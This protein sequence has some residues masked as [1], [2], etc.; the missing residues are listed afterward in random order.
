MSGLE[1][2]EHI[3][4]SLHEAALDDAC[5][6][7][8]SGLIDE[9]CGS[10]GNFLTHADGVCD[11]DV[12]I[13]SARF[14]YRGQ[15]RAD[16][17]RLYLE[18]YYPLDGRIPR[19]RQLPDSQV[20]HVGSLYTD[21]EKKTSPVYN[22]ALPLSDT[23]DSLNVRL[24]GP[25]GSRIIWVV[26]DPCDGEGWSSARVET[27]E[28]LL[29]HLRQYVHVRQALVNAHALGST[30]AGLLENANCGVI[31]L[32]PRGRIVAANDTARALL[33]EGDGLA[34]RE[35]LLCA[36]S[37]DDDAALQE[38]LAR[39]LPRFGGQAASGSLMLK[40]AAVSPRLVL[41]AV[42]VA[43]KRMEARPNR[44]AALMMVVDPASRGRIDPRVVEAVLGLTTAES[45]VAVMFAEG[46][47]MREIAVATGRSE[48]TIRWHIKN[49]Y[50]KHGLSRQV[51]L[52]QL[53]LSLSGIP[54]VPP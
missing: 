41:R 42:P 45:H 54:P 15:R 13:F 19:I 8:T 25:D 48:G 9:A 22:E 30:L 47:T 1:L 49:M 50:A 3:L 5:W 4:G 10:K 36:S 28:R 23:Q 52:V 16:L 32:D 34:D 35:G 20:E 46:Y 18:T 7:S 2:F 26:G 6:P 17:E 12:E 33:R 43:D 53:V 40:R 21:E 27:V 51:E 24:D 44:V 31:Q 39:A 11:G 14:C 38:L 37:P 29:P